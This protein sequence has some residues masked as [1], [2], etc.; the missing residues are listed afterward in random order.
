MSADDRWKIIYLPNK[1]VDWALTQ[2]FLHI[3]RSF[4]WFI[5]NNFSRWT[6]TRN[7]VLTKQITFAVVIV[8]YSVSEE[9][10]SCNL[11][12]TLS[13]F[14]TKLILTLYYFQELHVYMYIPMYMYAFLQFR[15]FSKFCCHL[16]WSSYY[17]VKNNSFIGFRR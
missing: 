2:L 8:Y 1:N 14:A 5:W 11:L 15:K 17:N 16:G 12:P 7:C 3:F 4:I 6:D 13:L 10:W 9:S